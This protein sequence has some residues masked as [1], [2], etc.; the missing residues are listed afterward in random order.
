MYESPIEKIYGD[1]IS[2]ITTAD[3]N[4]LLYEV[5]QAMGY[6]IYKTELARALIYDR[7]QYE[8]GY[9]DGLNS[10]WIPVSEGLPKK[11]GEYWVTQKSGRVGIYVFDSNGNSEEYWKRCA[12]AWMP[13]PESYKTESEE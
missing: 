8:K 13:L 2:D 1:I 10:K 7:N 12:L 6:H 5:R 3:E 9:E 11:D 4:G